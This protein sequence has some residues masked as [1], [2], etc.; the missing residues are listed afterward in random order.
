[1][2]SR[3]RIGARS[4]GRRTMRL[5]DDTGKWD[6]PYEAVALRLEKNKLYAYP[7]NTNLVS[8]PIFLKM[9]VNEKTGKECLW[10]IHKAHMT[11]QFFYHFSDSGKNE[12]GEWIKK[13]M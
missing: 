12:E 11:G 4:A 1:M 7:L 9:F 13:Q 6:I 5:I 10:A 2:I 8:K 3:K